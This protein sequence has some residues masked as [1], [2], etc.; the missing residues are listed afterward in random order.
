MRKYI[1]GM[2][3]IIGFLFYG[4]IIHSNPI[5]EVKAQTEGQNPFGFAGP[6]SPDDPDKIAALGVHYI[7]ESISWQNIEPLDGQFDFS[8]FNQPG[9]V[10]QFGNELVARIK[11]GNTFTPE[12]TNWWGTSCD[13]SLCA[14]GEN[15]PDEDA[16]CPPA[17]LSNNWSLENGYSQ[18]LTDFITR[19]LE[20]T[21]AHNKQIEY[22]I[23]GNE[24][25]S[26]TFW[27]G[28]ADQ[29]LKTRATIY[30]A[31]KRINIRLGTSYKL[32]DN[33]IA[34]IWGNAIIVENFCSS[35]QS[36]ID[37]AINFANR[38]FNRHVVQ[39]I[40]RVWLSSNVNC[41]EGGR[42]Y[43]VMKAMFAKDPNLGES[44]FDLM[45]FHFYE[46]WDVLEESIDWINEEMQKNGY[47]PKPL[48][49][50]EGGY[51]DNLNIPST[52]LSKQGVADDLPKLHTISSYKGVKAWLWLPF[53]ERGPEYDNYGYN[54]KG[55]VDEFQNE[56]PSY[57]SYQTMVNQL[58]EFQTV[59]KL[60]GTGT[61]Y[62]YKYTFLDKQPVYVLWDT[63]SRTINFSSIIPGSVKITHVD[64][65]SQ[66]GFS[67]S[68]GISESPIYL[69]AQE[70]TLNIQKSVDKISTYSGETVTYTI[71]YSN[72]SQNDI[73]S[74]R[75]EDPIP[76]GT[77]FVSATNGGTFDGVKV[78]WNLGT[79]AA[80]GSGTASFQV[81]VQ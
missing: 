2:V 24:V 48:I 7:R 66:T 44:T 43:Q 49:N 5:P 80:R 25:N 3:I 36:K 79:I 19:I 4:A 51:R 41:P 8:L 14:G 47:D 20:E 40:D 32:T 31:I 29:Y 74:A 23:P 73:L 17:D 1:F 45:A 50:T 42:D 54:W 71:L 61:N 6:S 38:N 68:V 57:R 35:E 18:S 12:T 81:R 75:I 37:Y 22:I 46:P 33:G 26:L 62:A 67:Q 27:H 60:E 53:T 58:K 65:A 13:L 52:D 21:H 55:L 56:L 78:I 34:S 72:S 11:L 77:T 76:T 28:S 70:L 59:E 15:C 9:I 30:N 69:E 16:D 39:D 10:E 64:G 63:S